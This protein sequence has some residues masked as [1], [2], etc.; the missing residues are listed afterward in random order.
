MLDAQPRFWRKGRMRGPSTLVQPARRLE[1]CNFDR[2]RPGFQFRARLRNGMEFE[3]HAAT[4]A[5]CLEFTREGL[6][7]TTLELNGA[8]HEGKL[9]QHHH[10]LAVDQIESPRNEE[11]P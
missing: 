7:D 10:R 9:N 6:N 1:P 4:T 3:S 5:V 11:A 2:H 8:G